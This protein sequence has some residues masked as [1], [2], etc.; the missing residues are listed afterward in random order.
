MSVST[1]AA[2]EDPEAT[3]SVLTANSAFRYLAAEAAAGLGPRT[4][5]R[6]WLVAFV[7]VAGLGVCWSMAS[8]IGAPPDEPA[9]VLRA[10]SLVRGQLLAGTPGAG[11]ALVV[12]VPGVYAEI[13]GLPACYEHNVRTTAGCAPALRPSRRTVSVFTPAGRYPPLYYAVVGLPSLVTSG[14]VSVYLMR[15]VS[16]V[17]NAVFLA[18]AFAVARTRS[19]SVLLTAAVAVAA[20]PMAIYLA[21]AVNPS[22][23]E[24]ASAIAFWT[25]AVVLVRSHP[26]WPPKG[27]VAI[28]GVS[29]I[30]MISMRGVSPLW[31][32][33]AVVLLLPS[34]VG[35]VD[36]RAWVRDR[37]LRGWAAAV[38]VAGVLDVVWVLA[39]GALKV[40]G[41]PVH[42]SLAVTVRRSTAMTGHL[43]DEAIGIF[44]SFDTPPPWLTRDLWYALAG[45]LVLVCVLFL[46]RR[47]ASPL[48]SWRPPASWS[49]SSWVSSRPPGTGSSVRVAT[50]CRC[51][52]ACRS[53]PLACSPL[54]SGSDRWWT[55]G[56]GSSP[57]SG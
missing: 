40:G 5:G 37:H 17:L 28:A 11:A 6:A 34:A 36:W 20:T 19:D 35:R 46:A 3:V 7:L 32:A 57:P 48:P 53:W 27:L 44:G 2:W 8:P 49:R 16:A 42:E 24:I 26:S 30:V 1:G 47:D 15:L 31:L 43:L 18:L 39:A 29:A 55:G 12:R 33:L 41:Q 25:T 54:D 14:T 13:P 21:G 9:H 51:M 50:S 38:A 56:R 45:G 4:F 52:S 10:V 22:G 23:L